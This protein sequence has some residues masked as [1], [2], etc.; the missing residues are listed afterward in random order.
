[1]NVCRTCYGDA[2]ADE[3]IPA[4]E[5]EELVVVWDDSQCELDA[6]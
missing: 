1:M 4:E 2:I 3:G 5:I 6:E